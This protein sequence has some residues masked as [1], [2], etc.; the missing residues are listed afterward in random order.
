M[1]N[2]LAV[3][4]AVM[5]VLYVWARIV[6]TRLRKKLSEAEGAAVTVRQDY[7]GKLAETIKANSGGWHML[8]NWNRLND[9]VH[10]HDKSL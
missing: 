2:V 8:A 3:A 1:N 6:G 7:E 5:L 10:G 4:L 9:A